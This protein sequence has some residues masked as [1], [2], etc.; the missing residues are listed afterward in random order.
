MFD[1]ESCSQSLNKQLKLLSEIQNGFS[2]RI[3]LIQ[4]QPLKR[5]V[6]SVNGLCWFHGQQ[7]GER[8]RNRDG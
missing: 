2:G 7:I 3:H 1:G 5:P 6:F 4:L 8:E